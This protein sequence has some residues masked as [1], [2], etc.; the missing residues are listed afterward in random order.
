MKAALHLICVMCIWIFS[1]CCADAKPESTNESGFQLTV[2][3]RDESVVK[4]RI[5]EGTVGFHS[6]ILGSLNL[7]WASIRSIKFQV[8]APIQLT[9]TNGDQLTGALTIEALKVRASYGQVDLP[10]KLIRSIQVS[11]ISP[12]NLP[13][14]LVS[15][16]SGEGDANDSIGGNNG[17]MT[18]SV[19]FGP[20]KKGQGFVFD[21]NNGSG[22]TLDNPDSL[23]LQDFTIEMWLKRANERVASYGTAGNANL[24]DSDWG[25]YLF[26]M[27][28]N[29]ELFFDKLG[30]LEPLHGPFI[31]DTKFHHV[32]VTKTRSVVAFY[33]DGKQYP[34]PC[35]TTKFTFNGLI[36]FGYH[37]N[38]QGQSFLGTLDEIGIFK[39]ALSTDEIQTIFTSQQ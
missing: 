39:R 14:G 33:L 3:L 24:F 6:P 4:G 1:L 16:W 26:G 32:A 8:G 38:S 28:A 31:T 23:H 13:E 7:S 35:Y 21:G 10:V 30:D 37:P 29:G 20:G 17:R 36:G 11:V 15:L 2:E 34:V 9:T 18:G 5:S 19:I 22:V 25:G 27:A 12:M